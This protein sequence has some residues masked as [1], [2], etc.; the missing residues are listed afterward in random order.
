MRSRIQPSTTY[1]Q[2]SEQQQVS[3]D[4]TGH[5]VHLPKTLNSSRLTNIQVKIIGSVGCF[6]QSTEKNH[7]DLKSVSTFDLVEIVSLNPK[8]YVLP[9]SISVANI[10]L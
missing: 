9:F 4:T 6:E 5:Q 1:Y 10:V 8:R 3:I 2:C 7:R